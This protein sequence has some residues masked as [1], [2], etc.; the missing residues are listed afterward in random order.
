MDRSAR[1]C[2]AS[3]T[4]TACP[5]R[6]LSTSTHPPQPTLEA[7]VHPLCTTAAVVE[8]EDLV[9]MAVQLR[10]RLRTLAR[11]LEVLDLAPF[12]IPLPD[13]ETSTKTPTVSRV[14]K[15]LA[16]MPSSHPVTTRVE[17]LA[18][19]LLEPSLDALARLTRALLDKADPSTLN[20]ATAA[21]QA[22]LVTAVTVVSVVLAIKP[23]EAT[24]R[25]ATATTVDLEGTA[26]ATTAE[27]GAEITGST[28]CCLSPNH[29]WEQRTRG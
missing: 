9:T 1:A 6:P 15:A 14:D 4:I 29:N 7:S 8:R 26:T 3:P 12:L 16:M 18:H 5:L 13:Q 27:V 11:L 23:L 10:V 2:M 17:D 25:A 20:K 24:S 21:T 19:L 22:T 28:R